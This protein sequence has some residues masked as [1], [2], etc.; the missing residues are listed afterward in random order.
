MG[1]LDREPV[2]RAVRGGMGPTRST[3]WPGANQWDVK[4]FRDNVSWV[5]I[6]MAVGHNTELIVGATDPRRSLDLHIPK[7]EQPIQALRDP[8]NHG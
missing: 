2:N 1:R 4:G 8:D 3:A 6:L 5:Q 7:S